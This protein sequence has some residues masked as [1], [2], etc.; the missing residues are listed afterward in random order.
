METNSTAW[1][2]FNNGTIGYVETFDWSATRKGD[3]Y[4]YTGSADKAIK[5]TEEQARKFCKYM[6]DCGTVG[7]WN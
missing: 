4:S 5:L 2:F 1:R 7:F 3:P 6:Q